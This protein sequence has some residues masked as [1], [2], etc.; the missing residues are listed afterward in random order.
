MK[1]VLIVLALLGVLAYL[2][3]SFGT[4]SKPPGVESFEGGLTV[5]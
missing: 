4:H 1:R 5:K 2:C 3:F